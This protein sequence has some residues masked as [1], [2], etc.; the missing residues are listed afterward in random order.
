MYIDSDDVPQEDETKFLYMYSTI[1]SIRLDLE[2]VSKPMGTRDN[3]TRT[4]KDLHY[5]HPQFTNGITSNRS[6]CTQ[7]LIYM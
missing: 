7:T 4:C 5:G 3:P 1:Y 2:R 6:S